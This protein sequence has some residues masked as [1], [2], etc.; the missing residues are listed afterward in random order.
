MCLK[1][2]IEQWHMY[3]YRVC[4]LF[5]HYFCLFAMRQRIRSQLSQRDMLVTN[6]YS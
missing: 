1:L 3:S 5:P 4:K 2:P 6:N